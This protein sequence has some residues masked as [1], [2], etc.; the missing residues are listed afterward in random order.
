MIPGYAGPPFN[1]DD[2]EPVNY[3]HWEYYVSSENMIQHTISMGTCPH[4]E[5]NYGLK[6]NVQ[7]HLLLPMNYDY[8]RNAGINFGYASPEFGVK[9]R[10]IQESENTPQIGIF[11]IIEVPTIKNKEFGNG[12]AQVYLP[13]W[14]QKSWDKFTTYGGTGYWINFG[15]NNKNLIFAGWEIQYD[16]TSLFTFGGELYYHSAI[17]KDLKS[18]TA[19]NLGGFINFSEQFH[20]IYSI[21]HN[22]TNDSF[23][24]SYIGLL[25][26]I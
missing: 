3:K 25:W 19:Y 6:P 8:T 22:L 4:I 23:I 18:V 14:I 20:L 16:F 21:G 11:P 5:V 12:K 17:A 13:V 10:F 2:P 15:T 9:Y 24:S 1:T 26:T 7:V